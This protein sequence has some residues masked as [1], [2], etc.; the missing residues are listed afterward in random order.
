MT[1]R[2]LDLMSRPVASATAAD[3]RWEFWGVIVLALTGTRIVV[4][5]TLPIIVLLTRTATASQD[6]AGRRPATLVSLGLVNV[7]VSGNGTADANTGGE[8]AV[9]ILRERFARGEVD[10]QELTAALDTLRSH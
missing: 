3:A 7:I 2:E 1:A 6:I 5:L 4:L 10:E 9:A 8:N